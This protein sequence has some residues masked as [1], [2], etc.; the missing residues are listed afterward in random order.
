MALF[1]NI[2]KLE[3][4]KSVPSNTTDSNFQAKP[5]TLDALKTLIPIRNLTEEELTAFAIEQK[6]ELMGAG[7]ILFR[8]GES[9]DSV[10]YLL[11]GKV[12]MEA[13]GGLQYEISSE[14]A[15]AR[16]PLSTGKYHG[17][18]ATAATDI[19][20]LRVSK[21]IMGQ[22]HLPSDMLV[23]DLTELNLPLK[24]KTSRLLQTFNDHYRENEL[25]LPT[26]PDIAIKLRKGI[27]QDIGVA[28]AAEIIK[29][30]PA[31]A[32]KLIHIANSPLYI[33]VTPV[34]N[35]LG[36]VNRLGLVAT[37]NLVV[38]FCVRQVFKA[39]NKAFLRVIKKLWKQ[40]IHI[41][42]LS[43]VLAS[44]NKGSVDPEEALLAGLICDIG[45]IPFLQFAENFPKDY[46]DSE[47]LELCIPVICG[48]VGTM[49][50]NNWGFP[51]E[52]VEVPMLAE[53]WYYDSGGKLTLADII[54]LSKLHNYI[55]MSKIADL[56]AIN[57][58]PA[59]G[60]LRDSVLTPEFTLNVLDNAKD[61][62]QKALNYFDG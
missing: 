2:F 46:Y 54:I 31:I 11:D 6:S 38:S 52:M 59:C 35:C 24:L 19:E 26:L 21:N 29:L 17:A 15:K 36:A 42:A 55:G 22:K 4:G 39:N 8:L 9:I 40:S 13:E 16:F 37:R 25:I 23:K 53:D 1:K 61:R 18:T 32:A 43:F 10:L 7:R 44:E 30:D 60:K 28:E 5:I 34:T 56:P 57:S 58:I 20:V 62:V 51:S 47:E 27:Q 12:T 50:L 14:T 33:S 49:I 48:P 45:I 3:K 41:S